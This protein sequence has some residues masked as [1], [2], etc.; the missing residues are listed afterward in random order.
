MKTVTVIIDLKEWSKAQF[1][2]S[3]SVCNDTTDYKDQMTMKQEFDLLRTSM[4]SR[5]ILLITRMVTELVGLYSVLLRY[6]RWAEKYL[7]IVI[8]RDFALAAQA[9][10][11]S[12]SWPL[13]CCLSKNRKDRKIKSHQNFQGLIWY[14]NST[15]EKKKENAKKK[16]NPCGYLKLETFFKGLQ[17]SFHNSITFKI[18]V[19][20]I[21]P[22]QHGARYL[23]WNKP[24]LNQ[25]N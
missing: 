4:Y 13:I 16:K 20:V 15:K 8:R 1:I 6:H 24:S 17:I 2:M 7:T 25:S 9:M 5:T 23:K 21:N 12:P 3:I 14:F 22:Q 11:N 19:M 18:S 10:F